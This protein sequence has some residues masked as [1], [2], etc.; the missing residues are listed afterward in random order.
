[1]TNSNRGLCGA[2]ES[3][4]GMGEGT[5][6]EPSGRLGKPR[7]VARRYL[8]RLRESRK[9]GFRTNKRKGENQIVWEG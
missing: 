3:G 2:K 7:T 4:R 9:G 5:T 8:G 1:M 6:A